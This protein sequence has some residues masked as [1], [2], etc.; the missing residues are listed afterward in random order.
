[1]FHL[2]DRH[3]ASLD[4]YFCA[5]SEN[6]MVCVCKGSPI[7]NVTF[8]TPMHPARLLVQKLEI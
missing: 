1:M 5:R 4:R 2:M 8:W 6:M 7:K 3:G